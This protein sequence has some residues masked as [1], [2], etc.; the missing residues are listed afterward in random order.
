MGFFNFLR[1]RKPVDPIS[2]AYDKAD[3]AARG[4]FDLFKKL[5][6]M[7]RSELKYYTPDG[8]KEAKDAAN[9]ADEK[10]WNAVQAA[11]ATREMWEKNT[12]VKNAAVESQS[13]SRMINE[14]KN[15]ITTL[16]PGPTDDEKS[17]IYT[18][19]LKI[20]M[21]AD[22]VAQM[23]RTS[24]NAAAAQAAAAQAA[25]AAAAAAGVRRKRKGKRTHRKRKCT[26][27]N[28]R[29]THRR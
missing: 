16:T 11:V 24:S 22:N 13:L 14:L 7:Q 27:R 1:K 18:E 25:Q 26:R 5:D 29:R 10:A 6:A 9:I 28:R 17:E 4:I 20:R 8:I 3:S 12:H 15:K 2:A 23:W 21:K 19:S